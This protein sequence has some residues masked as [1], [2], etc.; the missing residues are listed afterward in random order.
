M[1]FNTW[2]R[3][4]L[5]AG[6]LTVG[7]LPIHLK[8]EPTETQAPRTYME[9]FIVLFGNM[10]KQSRITKKVKKHCKIKEITIIK[11]GGW[12]WRDDPDGI[13]IV[14]ETEDNF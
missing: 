6:S 14:Q 12:G 2:D 1:D 10:N 9:M 7:S 4:A 5:H 11:E 3:R 13:E 8:T